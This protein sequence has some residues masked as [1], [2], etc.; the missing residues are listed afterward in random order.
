MSL[1]FNHTSE[2]AGRI[3]LVLAHAVASLDVTRVIRKFGCLKKTGVY[4]PLE[5]YPNYRL[6]KTS[7][8]RDNCRKVLLTV[9]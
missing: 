3:Q 2:V 5:I 7:P 4:F 9:A 6:R 8:R 1:S